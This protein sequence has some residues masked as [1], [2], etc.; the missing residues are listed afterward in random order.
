MIENRLDCLALTET[1]L[2]AKEEENRAVLSNL[3]PSDFNII[4]VPRVTRGGGVGF[5]YNSKF[6]AKLDISLKFTS[7]ECQTVLLDASSFTFR[8]VIIYRIPPNSK[9]KIQKSTFIEELGDLLEAT[10]TLSGKLMLLGD[11]N[12]H[13][14][15]SSD[16]EGRQL[17]SLLASF[18][19]EQHVTDATHVDGHTLDLVVSRV[20]DEVVQCC[21][22]GPFIS[23][24]NSIL[25]SLKSGKH[26]AIRKQTTFRKV[27]SIDIQKFSKEIILDF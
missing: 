9:N 22:V 18:G 10:A 17:T 25:I 27:K 1:W 3:V 2:S 13:L 15:N 26:H 6:K 4:H 5:I 8:F 21:K 7:F 11:F 14:D 12:V 16:P 23:D 20:T 19:M 24:H